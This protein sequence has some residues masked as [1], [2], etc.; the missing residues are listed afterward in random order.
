MENTLHNYPE[1]KLAPAMSL[2]DWIITLLITWIPLVGIVMLFVWAFSSD[3]NENKRN[4]AK[5]FLIIQLIAFV[6]VIIIYI[7]VFASLIAIYSAK[8]GQL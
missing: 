6:L 4:W 3:T 2:K 7:F 1:Q 5:A 8:S